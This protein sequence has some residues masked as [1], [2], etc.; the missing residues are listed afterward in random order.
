M[1]RRKQGPRAPTAAI[2]FDFERRSPKAASGELPAA[3]VEHPIGCEPRG[4]V[5]VRG[6]GDQT[7]PDAIGA[8]RPRDRSRGQLRRVAIDHAGKL[9][10][11]DQA[12]RI[13][14]VRGQR[15]GQVATKTLAPAEHVI[16]PIVPF[17]L[18]ATS[19]TE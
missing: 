7:A 9:V 11:N 19:G 17:G 2:E 3:R 13:V 5:L 4:D 15:P 16:W 6:H 8:N 10:A 1:M 18:S 14:A 12:A